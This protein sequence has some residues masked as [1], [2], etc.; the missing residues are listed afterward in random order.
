[1]PP[2]GPQTGQRARLGGTENADVRAAGNSR[3]HIVT[4]TPDT[5]VA[6]SA[7]TCAKQSSGSNTHHTPAF[8]VTGPVSPR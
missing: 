5:A 6:G 4:S 7:R 2:D 1:M 3:P 8:P